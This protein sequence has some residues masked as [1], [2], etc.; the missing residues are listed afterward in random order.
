M[1][2]VQGQAAIGIE[3]EVGQH[4]RVDQVAI[5]RV[6]HQQFVL[7]VV[8]GQRPERIGRGQGALVEVQG[9]VGFRRIDRLAVLVDEITDVV[10]L[11]GGVAED[12]HVGASIAVQIITLEVIAG[13]EQIVA[14]DL[15]GID[16][17]VLELGKLSLG[18]ADAV[19][20]RFA[21]LGAEVGQLE[22]L[23]GFDTDF[24]EAR[25]QVLLDILGRSERQHEV[26]VT[27]QVRGFAHGRRGFWPVDLR[28][29]RRGF[30]F[31]VMAQAF[32]LVTLLDLPDLGQI[33]FIE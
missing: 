32:N 4:A 22:R 31:I 26:Q 33:L 30:A 28:R 25:K 15:V 1:L 9:V 21:L 7:A 23:A 10:G 16:F 3:L 20:Q 27:E 24:G 29:G 8:H 5:E 6:G 17:G 12:P 2:H 13:A 18:I 11:F 14:A 19:F